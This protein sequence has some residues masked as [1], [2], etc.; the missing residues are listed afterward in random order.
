LPMVACSPVGTAVAPELPTVG[1]VGLAS[2]LEVGGV[3]RT[4]SGVEGLLLPGWFGF[5]IFVCI[6]SSLLRC[7]DAGCMDAP[8]RGS[9]HSFH[10]TTLE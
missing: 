2:K 6:L 3:G 7:P 9:T 1:R 5:H 4:G 10:D 8:P